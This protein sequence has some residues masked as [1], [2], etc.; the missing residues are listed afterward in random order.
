MGTRSFLAIKKQRKSKP[1]TTT[2]PSTENASSS[3][4]SSSSLTAHQIEMMKQMKQKDQKALEYV[5]ENFVVWLYTQYDGG[6][7]GHGLTIWEFLCKFINEWTDEQRT[8]YVNSLD[9]IEEASDEFIEK[10]KKWYHDNDGYL[11]AKKDD[12]FNTYIPCT[13]YCG[14]KILDIIGTQKGDVKT[15]F[16][17][18]SWPLDGLYCEYGYIVDFDKS[19]VHM[20][21]C[22]NGGACRLLKPVEEIYGYRGLHLVKTFKFDDLPKTVEDYFKCLGIDDN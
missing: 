19:E 5:R 11:Q 17:Q 1:S 16:T 15:V 13:A 7:H 3:S 22:G 8:N 4:A 2:K 6:F 9:L 18:P 10:A 12:H 21:H 14:S 20:M